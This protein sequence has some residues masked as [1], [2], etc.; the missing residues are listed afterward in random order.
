MASMATTPAATNGLAGLIDQLQSLRGEIDEQAKRHA[1]RLAEL[2]QE[3]QASARNLVHYL[4][5]RNFDLR[6]LQDRLA[7]LGL[8]SIGR[9]EPQ[10]KATLDALLLHLRVMNGQHPPP[11]NLAEVYRPFDQMATKLQQNTTQLLGDAPRHR[12]AY[13]MVT[14]PAEAAADYMLVHRL[15]KNGTDCIRV[16]CAH[17]DQATWARIV[18]HKRHAERALGRSCKVLMDLRGPKLRSGP[19]ESGPGVLKIRPVRDAYGN[20]T[21]PAR[22]WLHAHE[23]KGQEADAADASVHVEA[24]WLSRCKS[25]DQVSLRDARGRKRRL[26]ITQAGP[27]G[28]WAESNKTVYLLNGTRLLLRGS[29]WETAVRGLPPHAGSTIVRSGDTLLLTAADAPGKPALIDPDGRLLSPAQIP[30]PVPEIY[31]DACPGEAIAFDDGRI[32][33]IIEARSDDELRVRISHTR[34]ASERL[35]ADQGIN[36]PDTNLDLPALSDE[37][38]HD[39][40]FVAEHADLVGL[41]FANRPE[42]VSLLRD[43]LLEL[44][45]DDIGVIVK[46]ETR[47]GFY[48]LP[49]ILFE[50]LKFPAC[51]VMIARGDLAAECGFERMAE[52]QEEMLWVC[53]SAHVPVIWATQVL[54][55]LTKRGH[56]TR[57]EISD[58]SMSQEAEC[59]MLNKGPYVVEAVRTL[60]DI[61]QRMQHH[62]TKK[63]SLLRK[64]Q[65]AATF[66]EQSR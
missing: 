35:A 6:P 51:G 44:G 13:I 27:P 32:T 58:A 22:I 20:V 21:R 34:K 49:G 40:P 39:L 64:L 37:D 41:S 12:R 38:L 4:T 24:S 1:G 28:C 42:D 62:Q 54:E 16:N 26:N 53:E 57:A 18:E 36:L 30:V 50:A 7:R 31:R 46:I 47:R 8:S 43:K 2:P 9:A 63:R 60:D 19:F 66:H 14:M 5:L 45:H 56:A 29:G 33:G 23:A 61:L 3:R 10:V 25:G 48:N 52:I 11:A 59:V 65:L 17:D 15:L 55:G